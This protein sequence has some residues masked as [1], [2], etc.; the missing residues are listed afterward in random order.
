[1]NA[2]RGR[3]RFQ[4][5]RKVDVPFTIDVFRESR[6]RRVVTEKRVGHFPRRARGFTWRGARRLGNG[7][8]FVRF[9]MRSGGASD[10]RRIALLKRGG[11]FRVRPGF[12]AARRCRLIRLARLT[13][14]VFGGTNRKPLRVSARLNQPG[15]ITMTV[16]RGRKVV[17]RKRFRAAGTR[18]R[19]F[20]VSLRR[21]L[22]RGD[23]RATVVA[24]SGS[25]AERVTL[26]GRRL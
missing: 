25:T 10:A 14:P 7:F 1:R 15:S 17:A 12:H 18:V 2:S 13:R 6:G 21:T 24:R 22:R 26:T 5:A 19:R 23:Y 4:V 3:L 9:I 16:R 20:R 11:R 8:Y